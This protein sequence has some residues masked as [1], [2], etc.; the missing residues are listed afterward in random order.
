MNLTSEKYMKSVKTY[1]ATIIL[2]EQTDTLDVLGKII[3][4]DFNNRENFS[5]KEVE[6][7]LP[8]F[9]GKIKQRPPAF[10]AKKINGIRLYKLARKDV[11]VHLKP[12]YV[13]IEDS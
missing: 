6:K 8:I 9:I 2:G 1:R 10:S 12:V 5:I 7:I 4:K 3:K 11:F 13:E